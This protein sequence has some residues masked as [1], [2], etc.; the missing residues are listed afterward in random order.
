L[1]NVIR[2]AQAKEVV[3]SWHH[4]GKK[5]QVVV[6][7][8]GHGFDIVSVGKAKGFGLLGMRERLLALGGTLRIDSG[9]GNGTTLTIELP[10]SKRKAS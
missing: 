9:L 10:L 6:T 7:D 3:I 2:H 8:D 4:I 5:L 1:T